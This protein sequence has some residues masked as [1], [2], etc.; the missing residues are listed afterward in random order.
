[1]ERHR[2]KDSSSV[3]AAAAA[4]TYEGALPMLGCLRAASGGILYRVGATKS[5]S[6]LHIYSRHGSAVRPMRAA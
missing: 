6:L 3:V 4:L 1:M 5:D 2:T